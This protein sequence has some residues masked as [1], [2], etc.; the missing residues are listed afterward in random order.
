MPTNCSVRWIFK[1][2]SAGHCMF[3]VL[4]SQKRILEHSYWDIGT[5]TSTV[6]TKWYFLCCSKAL[7]TLPNQ[8]S[9]CICY[10][11]HTLMTNV[12]IKKSFHPA[13]LL[14]WPESSQE[15]VIPSPETFKLWA[16]EFIKLPLPV[17]TL[18]SPDALR[19]TSRNFDWLQSGVK[20]WEYSLL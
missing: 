10:L 16:E 15:H 12:N 8:L 18:L 20:N 17:L 19:S 2:C 4:L 14:H 13:F 5:S 9:G 1:Y 3:S 7:S 6:A 11:V